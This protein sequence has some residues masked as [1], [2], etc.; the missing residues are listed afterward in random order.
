[1]IL[2]KDTI[3]KIS[4]ILSKI[5]NPPTPPSLPNLSLTKIILSELNPVILPLPL[6]LKWTRKLHPPS[7]KKWESV[8]PTWRKTKTPCNNS[9]KPPSPNQNL[10]I[11]YRPKA[12]VP[13]KSPLITKWT[14]TAR[15]LV[16]KK[17]PQL[18]YPQQNPS[19]LHPRALILD[20]KHESKR[21]LQTRQ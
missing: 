20:P 19:N 6:L 21:L 17:S 3:I 7:Q 15:K 16:T 1:M 8:K 13:L 5:Q 11:T 14:P 12:V 18:H 10:S 2:N 9:S 4:K